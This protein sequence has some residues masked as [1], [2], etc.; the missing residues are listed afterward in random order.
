MRADGGARRFVLYRDGANI[1][2]HS[3]TARKSGDALRVQVD[4]DIEVKVLGFRAYYYTHQNIETWKDGV[5]ESFSSRTDEDGEKFSAAG[6]RR[7]GALV[8][9]GSKTR[10]KA[11]TSYWNVKNFQSTPWFS[12]Q[13][14]DV[15]NLSFA[16][17]PWRGGGAR[18][19]VRGDF[20]TT[21]FYDADGEW[22]GC[23]FPGRGETISYDQ[24]AAGPDFR[25]LIA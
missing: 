19:A 2:T 22:R 10:A 24:V 18:W 9:N 16:K 25:T 14:G 6:Q 4:I 3:V 5:L 8:I 23:E 13:T 1:G 11:P 20:E 7:D 17:S 15:M 21:L 12:T